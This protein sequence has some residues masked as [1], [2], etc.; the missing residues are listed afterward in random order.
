[1][2]ILYLGID[3]IGKAPGDRR[4]FLGYASSLPNVKIFFS[5][6]SGVN[7]EVVVCA[8]GGDL[9]R[10]LRLSSHVP[11]LVL[12]YSDH[13]LVEESFLKNHCRIPLGNLFKRRE[14][15]VESHR[16]I[17]MKLL[18]RAD[19]VICP[20]ITHQ[21][22]LKNLNISSN[23]LTDFFY[24]E[25]NFN[26]TNFNGDG[27][28]FWE[29]QAVNLRHLKIISSVLKER[30]NVP[31]RIVSDPHFGALGGRFLKE[32]SRAYCAR[33]LPNVDYLNWS[34]ENVNLAAAKSS[35]GVVPIDIHDHFSAAKP[36][37][38]IVYMWLLGLV[39]LCS[40]TES[41][42]MLAKE[43]GVNF[44]CEHAEDWSTAIDRLLGRPDEQVAMAKY[45][46]NFALTEYSNERQA[47]K[48]SE[49]FQSAGIL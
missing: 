42:A 25:V 40:P 48:W 44:L 27:S 37:N 5:E 39:A 33:F 41:Y 12:D 14:F 6:E 20:S 11:K 22:Y 43:T 36:E 17:I 18:K 24:E 32:D 47:K 1:M 49:A 23:R 21:N 34:M 9:V 38:K 15:S 26:N 13:Y 8:L 29:G 46:H 19:L 7:Y 3:P 16:R 28:I 10:A 31:I 45:L 2:N 30:Q 35:I 4:R